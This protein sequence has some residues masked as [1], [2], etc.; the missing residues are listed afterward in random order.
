MKWYLGEKIMKQHTH[1]HQG[2][3]MLNLINYSY[4]KKGHWTKETS[5]TL[6]KYIIQKLVKF[7]WCCMSKIPSPREHP[8]PSTTTMQH[9]PMQQ[10]PSFTFPPCTIP[11]QPCTKP[12]H[13][14]TS[15]SSLSTHISWDIQL[16]LKRFLYTGIRLPWKS[17]CRQ[18]NI[19][20]TR[21]RY[22]NIG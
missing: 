5:S 9:H 17:G 7:T 10:P 11:P 12:P 20:W 22:S 13:T 2:N 15:S 8:S 6:F 1:L 18:I 19:F 14:R 16:Y 3:P 4:G 21:Q